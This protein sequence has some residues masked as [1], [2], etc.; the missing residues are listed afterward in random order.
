MRVKESYKTPLSEQMFQKARTVIPGG[1]NANIKFFA[2]YPLFMKRAEGSKLIDVDGNVY[3]DYLLTF[4]AIILGHGH[5][6]IKET[7]HRLFT[8]IGTTTFGTS[9][10][11]EIEAAEKLIQLF[12]GIE[13]VRFTNSGLEATL[14]AIR[15]A[16]AYT[17]K[18]RIAKFV[19]HY[20]GSHDAVL[21]SVNPPLT[22]D[23]ENT[24][25]RPFPDSLGLSEYYAKN[26][27]V[28]PFNEIGLTEALLRE[29]ADELAAVIMEPLLGGYIPAE[30][31][32]MRR[33]RELT[34]ELNILLIFDEIKTGLRLTLGGAQNIYGVVPDLTALGKIIGGGF[35]VG[36]VGGKKEIMEILSPSRSQRASDVLFHSGT[37]N[38]HP[39]ALAA[40]L[41][42]IDVLERENGIE[43]L[44]AY[45]ETLKCELAD[46]YAQ[47]GVPFQPLGMGAI[48]NPLIL[49]NDLSPEEPIRH[50]RDVQLKS[51]MNLRRAI[52]EHV[53]RN[54]IY[55]KPLNRYS[56]SLAHD[57][58]DLEKTLQAH[59][60]ALE[61]VLTRFKR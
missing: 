19:G 12:P 6:A 4:G 46:L 48:F 10:H 38:G 21:V 35:P 18:K 16:I 53:L 27:L 31:D 2:P 29:H 14:L 33:L 54:G 43:K 28:L 45:T 50:Y 22:D 5:P 7:I 56:L 9:H 42:V 40:G 25:P 47:Y 36:A 44:N 59:S 11:L 34:R 24:P 17:G 60:E 26:T 39:F 55:N 58:D 20:H 51:D 15:A 23:D 13:M 57:E 8:E 61:S 1:V 32:F 3:I 41:A 30:A 52:D 37:F 49:K